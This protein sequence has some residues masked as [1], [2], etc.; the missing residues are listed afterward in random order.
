MYVTVKKDSVIFE[1]VNYKSVMLQ[2]N[3]NI[4]LKI[5]ISMKLKDLKKLK[6]I[7]HES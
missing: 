1:L 6:R 4:F 2:R 3:L 7:K 5:Q